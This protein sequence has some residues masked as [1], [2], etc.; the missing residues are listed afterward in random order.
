MLGRSFFQ[1]QNKLIKLFT[2]LVIKPCCLGCIILGV[3]LPQGKLRLHNVACPRR[4]ESTEDSL[5]SSAG[6]CSVPASPAR[7]LPNF[8][9]KGH[10]PWSRAYATSPKRSPPKTAGGKNSCLER[11]LENQLGLSRHNTFAK[12][13]RKENLF[14]SGALLRALCRHCAELHALSERQKH[15][16]GTNAA[17]ERGSPEEVVFCS[18][19]LLLSGAV[20]FPVRCRPSPALPLTFQILTRSARNAGGRP[21][22]AIHFQLGIWAATCREKRQKKKAGWRGKENN[23]QAPKAWRAASGRSEQIDGTLQS[24]NSSTRFAAVTKGDIVKDTEQFIPLK[25]GHAH[26]AQQDFCCLHIS[27]FGAARRRRGACVTCAHPKERL[28]WRRRSWEEGTKGGESGYRSKRS[29]ARP[30]EPR[31]CGASSRT[32]PATWVSRV[33]HPNKHT[34]HS[35]EKRPQTHS[36]CADLIRLIH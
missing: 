35:S 5:C 26:A 17:L 11:E 18:V 8:S 14:Y 21:A 30:A 3:N 1:G 25:G 13:K 36:G 32:V 4:G 31:C 19:L 15:K 16:S 23:F 2:A 28:G 34:G 24:L 22:A 33:S 27:L 10:F 29:S 7:P 9:A 20:S 12:R 6:R